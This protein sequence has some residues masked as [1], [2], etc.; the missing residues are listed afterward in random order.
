MLKSESEKDIQKNTIIEPVCDLTY[1]SEMTGGKKN[2]MK[3]I[4]DVFL[5]QIP[6]ELQ[7]ITDGIAKADY[8]VIKNYSH[9]MKS[10]VSIMSISILIP[11][12]KEM[13]DLGAKATDLDKI[14]QLN[15]Q[16]NL[17]CNQA[18]REIEKEKLNYI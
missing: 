15:Q 18:I 14:K 13:E 3:A 5:K 10:S 7:S 6:E 8:L 12:L 2:M 17:I 9:T 16:L 1:L 11:I 4:M